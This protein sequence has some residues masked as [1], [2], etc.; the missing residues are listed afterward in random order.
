MR[1]LTARRTESSSTPRTLALLASPRRSPLSLRRSQEHSAS[2][3][4]GGDPTALELD[5]LVRFIDGDSSAGE[6]CARINSFAW[7]R[8]RDDGGHRPF[9]AGS[10]LI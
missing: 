8:K 9:C 3:S 7:A 6:D 4:T 1:L 2:S 10:A 5:V